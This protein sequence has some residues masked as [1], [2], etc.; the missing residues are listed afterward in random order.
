MANVVEVKKL[1]LVAAALALQAATCTSGG[2][3]RAAPR[4][5]AGATTA[6]TTS[7]V[8]R[9]CE[10]P[11]SFPRSEEPAQAERA[12]LGGSGMTAVLGAPLSA[13]PGQRPHARIGGSPAVVV[14]E[15]RVG[16]RR[17]CR[18]VGADG[19]LG[20]T[21][22]RP[23]RVPARVVFAESKVD[24][25]DRVPATGATEA[26][27]YRTVTAPFGVIVG[28]SGEPH[29]EQ[30]ADLG[31]SDSLGSTWLPWLKV[32][33][34]RD[35]GWL[36]PSDTRVAWPT[37]EAP[38]RAYQLLHGLVRHWFLTDAQPH[39]LAKAPAAGAPVFSLPDEKAAPWPEEASCSRADAA[40]FPVEGEEPSVVAFACQHPD[41][42]KTQ[43]LTLVASDGGKA[44][45]V[46]DPERQVHVTRVTLA[47]VGGDAAPEVLIEIGLRSSHAF[48][49]AL[50]VAAREPTPTSIGLVS[51]SQDEAVTTWGLDRKTRAIV[52]ARTTAA[53]SL[54]ARRIAR[55]GD[56]LSDSAAHL[57]VSKR[58]ATLEQA[59]QATFDDPDALVVA[60][61][62]PVKAWGVASL[63]SEGR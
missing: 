60:L 21:E 14:E 52:V 8:R 50:L 15:T 6:V 54:E 45:Y 10:A 58:F 1:V 40:F 4:G 29:P 57:A 11:R 61:D 36:A 23:E 43:I 56:A 47:D 19:S 22:C 59:R 7:S 18:V 49:R 3:R 35:E 42:G 13:A 53:A 44:H 2:V 25:A 27:S 12:G 26:P 41:F 32:R 31:A 38:E 20:W 28:A 33:A 9:R 17:F 30:V 46:I 24:L 51:L 39:W 16:Q 55:V 37:N 5:S 62:Y 63:R 34:G 48:D